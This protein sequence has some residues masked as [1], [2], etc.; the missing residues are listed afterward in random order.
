MDRS[1]VRTH[2]CI[3]QTDTVVPVLKH[4]SLL[5][6]YM[7]QLFLFLDILLYV[8]LTFIDF[9]VFSVYFCIYWN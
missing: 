9:I 8:V 6:Y 5:T 4:I 1:P 7:A 3:C 2:P